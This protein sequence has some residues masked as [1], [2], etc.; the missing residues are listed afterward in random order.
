MHAMDATHYKE[1]QG[2]LASRGT[3]RRRISRRHP[4][5][6]ALR[7]CGPRGRYSGTDLWGGPALRTFGAGFI[8][9]KS[10]IRSL[11]S[12]AAAGPLYR[13]RGHSLIALLIAVPLSFGIAVF[14]DPK[15]ALTGCA[16]PISTGIELLASIEYRLWHLGLFVLAPI[17]QHSCN[18]G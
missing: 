11:T 18:P 4:D 12:T 16:A 9:A 7:T 3:R 15:S 14:L 1:L 17:L 6:G 5:F 2:H 13:Y 10:G 8:R